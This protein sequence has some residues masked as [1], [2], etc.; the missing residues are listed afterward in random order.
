MA[1]SSF[2]VSPQRRGHKVARVRPA[3]KV[4]KA[5]GLDG[6]VP[7]LLNVVGGGAKCML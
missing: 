7:E 6:I 3:L 1:H 4:G 5:P 2:S